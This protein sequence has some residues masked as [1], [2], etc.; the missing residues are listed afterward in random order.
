[1]DAVT[2]P[3]DPLPGVPRPPDARRRHPHV[4]N[5]RVL[6]AVGR[7]G[8][9]RLA[10]AV[11]TFAGSMPFVYVH[12]VWFALWILANQGLFGSVL[13]FD[14]FP[15][16]LLTMVVSLEAIFLSTFV[17]ISQNRDAKRQNVRADLDFETNVRSEVWTWHIGR[18]LGLDPAEI[19]GH[20]Q[21]A[22][23]HG[24]DGDQR[25]LPAT[26]PSATAPSATAPPDTSAIPDTSAAPDTSSPGTPASP[27]GQA[28][29]SA[30]LAPTVQATQT[31]P[32]TAVP[33]DGSEPPPPDVPRQPA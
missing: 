12:V 31:A 25:P 20:V 16:G 15:Y 5:E 6:V 2:T 26:A 17:M 23:R 3:P 1:M 29:P 14:P 21:A 4:P 9:E 22:L 19:E 13:V 10:D 32:S 33:S 27:T 8:Q 11:T 30:Q 24:W 18:R 7:G 28:T